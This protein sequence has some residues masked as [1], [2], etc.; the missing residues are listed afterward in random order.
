MRIIDTPAVRVHHPADL[1]GSVLSLV[2][3]AV[4]VVLSAYAHGTTRGIAEDVRGVADI[5]R[6][7]VIFPIA[8]LEWIVTVAAPI[9]VLAELFWRRL[10]RQAAEAVLGAIVALL[11]ARL[12][13]W[14][15][16][17]WAITALQNEFS[18]WANGSWA[19]TIPPLLAAVAGMLTASGTR[20]R[21]R[22]AGWSWNFLWIV[23]GVAM[24]TG[25]ITLPGALLTVLIGRAS[26]LAL[27]YAFGVQSERAYGRALVEG[28][29]RA[30]FAPTRLIRVRDVGA[31]GNDT[32]EL[33]TD[34]AAIAITRAGDNR[35]Y[36]MTTAD[37][38]RL[39]VVALDGDRQVVGFLTRLWRSMRLRGIE[40]RAVVSLRQAAERAA[41]LSYAAWSAGVCTP[42]LLGMAEAE[43]SMLLIQQHA[44]GAVP[45]RDLPPEALSDDVLDAVWEQLAIAHSA[46]L[47]HRAITSDVVLV[48]MRPNAC[49]PDAPARTHHEPGAPVVLLTGWENGDVASSELARRIDV[50]TLLTVL[51]L[52]VGPERA[53]ASAVRT[54]PDDL[55]TIGPLLQPIAFPRAT[56]DEAR[57]NRH[58]MGELREALLARLPKAVVEPERIVRFGAR[59]I[60]MIVLGIAAAFAVITSLNLEQV[61][62]AVRQASPVWALVAFV[63]GLVTFVG[64][65][66]AMVAFAPIKLSVWRTTLVQAAAAY[67]SLAA[68]A[69]VGPAALNMRM[70]TRRGVSNALSV[71]SVGLVQLAQFVTTMLMLVG[72]SIATGTDQLGKSLPPRTI[73]LA[74]AVIAVAAAAL[75]LVPSARHWASERVVPI[76][77]TTWPRLVQLIGQPRRFVVAIGGSL[78]MSLGYVGAFWASLAAFGQAD[79]LS[80]VDIAIVYLLG[81]AV[82]AMVPV[83]GG[84]GTVETA[85]SLAL[86]GAGIPIAIATPTVLVFRA[87]TFW[88]RIPIGWV[89][90]RRLQRTGE[91]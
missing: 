36:A 17:T 56:R 27:R 59:T 49:P 28:I 25:L 69:A 5:V 80:L 30:G 22:S 13:I 79:R 4:V 15:I 20:S 16:E 47:T 41:L 88:A 61:L 31:D 24:I 14:L 33:V 35:V 85:L 42:R 78:L 12:A 6:N 74:I 44:R 70:L 89:A 29:R 7:L 87:V 64:S 71:A 81:N 60:L 19:V 37:G 2:G 11:S 43:D 58:M 90:M 91:L 8:V 1:M 83:P 10:I 51:A 48:N 82:G 54:I 86:A 84:L 40:G 52:K 3:I 21:R 66:L 34:L 23:L 65:A 73:L 67:L 45:V 32:G 72:L 39:D 53:V 62:D 26:G 46:G 9:A 55:A 77:Q 75:M 63:L 50:A 68:P 38:E 57:E 18:V 76:W